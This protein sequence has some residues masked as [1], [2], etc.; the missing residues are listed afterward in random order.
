[1]LARGMPTRSRESRHATGLG[2][3]EGAGAQ[4]HVEIGGTK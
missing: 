2:S 1:M 4:E 3:C